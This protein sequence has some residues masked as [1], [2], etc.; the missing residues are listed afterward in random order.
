MAAGYT[1]RGA[2]ANEIEEVI[3]KFSNK[4]K[5]L[6]NIVIFISICTLLVT[7][8]FAYLD[9]VGDTKWQQ[10][11]QLHYQKMIKELQQ[12]NLKNKKC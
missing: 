6:H 12:I 5:I 2:S 3:N 7:L 8:S 11:Q 10:Q 4:T 9:Y 1:S